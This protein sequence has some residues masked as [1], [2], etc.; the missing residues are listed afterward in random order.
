M[1]EHNILRQ[2]PSQ[3]YFKYND[4][5]TKASEA[6]LTALSGGP[7]FKISAS[8]EANSDANCAERYFPV[9]T[10]IYIAYQ[11][12]SNL[13][14]ASQQFYTRFPLSSCSL[15][16]ASNKLLKLPAPKPSKLFRWI[17]SMNTVGLSIRCLVN[18]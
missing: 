3:G 1:L 17:I 8:E 7:I 14:D 11:T 6:L 9:T 13:S 18:S 15:S 16:M 12:I 4:W 2:R 5:K 10:I